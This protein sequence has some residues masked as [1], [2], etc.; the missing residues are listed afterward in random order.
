MTYEAAYISPTIIQ[1]PKAHFMFPRLFVSV[2]LSMTLCPFASLIFRVH[3]L[4]SDCFYFFIINAC[5][6]FSLML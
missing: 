6:L 5:L 4:V 1:I 3:S 2:C